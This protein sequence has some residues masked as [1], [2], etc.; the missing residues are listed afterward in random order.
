MKRRAVIIVI[1]I[2]L[3]VVLTAILVVKNT[4]VSGNMFIGR[5]PAYFQLT[6]TIKHQFFDKEFSGEKMLE[7][8]SIL[9]YVS[10]LLPDDATQIDRYDKTEPEISIAFYSRKK[11][12]L[13]YV[14]ITLR[15]NRI[16]VV[17]DNRKF[18]ISRAEYKIID[19]AI[20]DIIE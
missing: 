7:A 2:L 11:E 17:L 19:R 14:G 6:I 4:G 12:L 10:S 1:I 3:I 20:N 13:H 15:T 16:V 18:T 8:E 5:K 9:S